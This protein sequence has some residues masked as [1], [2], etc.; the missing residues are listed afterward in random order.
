MSCITRSILLF[1]IIIITSGYTYKN[2]DITNFE[3]RRYV[4]PQLKNIVNDYKTLLISITPIL[5]P[6]DKSFK[7]KMNLYKI[8]SKTPKECYKREGENCKKIFDDLSV[9]LNKLTTII[10]NFVD[11]SR[12]KEVSISDQLKSQH[13]KE[14]LKLQLIQLRDHLHQIKLELKF[15]LSPTISTRLLKEYILKTI[16]K[17]DDYYLSLSDHRFRESLQDY[18]SSFIVP[19]TK[20]ILLH[21]NRKVFIQNINE[22]NIRINALAMRMTKLNLPISNQ[23]KTLIKI[24]H[25]RWN[26][27]LK[28]SLITNSKK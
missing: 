19:V 22:F 28:V 27:I 6:L 17:L 12:Q 16:I 4:K 7:I 10:S 9:D 21:D 1:S 18:H 24:I 8:E 2:I 20:H 23:A 5:K 13:T 25:H 3:Y 15:N 26:N 14:I 11:G